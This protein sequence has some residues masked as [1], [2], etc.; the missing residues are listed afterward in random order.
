MRETYTKLEEEDRYHQL[1]VTM[2]E[3]PDQKDYGLF[4]ARDHTKGVVDMGELPDQMIF[5]RFIARDHEEVGVGWRYLTAF[6]TQR[7]QPRSSNY[8]RAAIGLL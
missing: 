6:R 2:G 3:L 1:Q 4:I 5:V 7:G 8:V